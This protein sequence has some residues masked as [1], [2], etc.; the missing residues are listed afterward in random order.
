M[1]PQ[2][3]SVIDKLRQLKEKTDKNKEL[4]STLK[5]PQTYSYYPPYPYT[6]I[7]NPY[8]NIINPTQT[9]QVQTDD[10]YNKMMLDFEMRNKHIIESQLYY[11]RSQN[12]LNDVLSV[13]DNYDELELDA[14]LTQINPQ[15]YNSVSGLIKS[16]PI[17]KNINIST[18][19]AN[20]ASHGDIKT[21]YITPKNTEE[22]GPEL[23]DLTEYE[24]SLVTEFIEKSY[25][26]LI[27][28][29]KVYFILADGKLYK[30]PN[31]TE[32]QI[33][34]E[35]LEGHIH[36]P[37]IDVIKGYIWSGTH[38]YYLTVD[39]DSYVKLMDGYVLKTA[40]SGL[41]IIDEK[42]N[43]KKQIDFKC[44]VFRKINNL[45]IALYIKKHYD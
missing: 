43:K 33:M 25:A 28:I 27:K 35:Q 29:L 31:I 34:K 8:S 18:D 32:I 3:Q 26:H 22:Q 23:S 6:N 40:N 11:E 39:E 19:I 5:M 20:G 12:L 9:E 13:V 37:D 38:I 24:Q 15:K 2:Q 45:D 30:L 42:N 41:V 10:L 1:Y 7:A 44:P 16:I 17:Q 21:I 36:V 14:R 4:I